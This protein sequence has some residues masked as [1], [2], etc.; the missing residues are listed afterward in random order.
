MLK[1]VTITKLEATVKRTNLIL[2]AK[3]KLA[4]SKRIFSRIQADLYFDEQHIKSFYVGIPYY[5]AGKKEF[6]LRSLLSLEEISAG[7]HT[8][9]LEMCGLW[10]YATP[11]DLKETTIEY[12]PPVKTK[13]TRKVPKVKKID[14]PHIAVVTDEAKKLYREMRERWK[15]EVRAKRDR[16]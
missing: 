15:K 9:K 3:F 11:S 7:S 6:P 14:G 1:H 10:H 5:F 8:I 16:W 4:A 13:I 12:Q 2:I